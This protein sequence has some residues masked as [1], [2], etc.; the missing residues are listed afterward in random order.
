MPDDREPPEPREPLPPYL[1][2]A[3][4]LEADIMSGKL[5][6]GAPLPSLNYLAGT[7]GVARNT[8]VRAIQVLKDKGLV[9]SR[10][11]WG[12]FVK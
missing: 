10:Q 6:K 4:D 9:E 2:I 12:T 7:Y 3:A 8:A 1:R 11:G 5:A